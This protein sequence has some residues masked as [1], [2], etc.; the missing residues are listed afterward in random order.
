MRAFLRQ[1]WREWLPVAFLA[2]VLAYALATSVFITLRIAQVDQGLLAQQRSDHQT[3]VN[4]QS[5]LKRVE[6]DEQRICAAAKTAVADGADPR[7]AAILCP[8]G[9]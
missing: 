1:E 6:A 2:V 9:S 7:L 4:H 5:L 8:K 3:L